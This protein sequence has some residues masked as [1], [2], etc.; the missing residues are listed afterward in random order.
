[1]KK[2][3]EPQFQERLRYLINQ[4]KLNDGM[5]GESGK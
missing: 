4:L 1:M 2:A 3:K 5:T